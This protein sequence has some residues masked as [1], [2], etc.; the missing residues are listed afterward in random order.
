MWRYDSRSPKG[1]G[2]NP[3]TRLREKGESTLVYGELNFASWF[4]IIGLGVES[5]LSRLL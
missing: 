3:A 5:C 1:R 2:V 4:R